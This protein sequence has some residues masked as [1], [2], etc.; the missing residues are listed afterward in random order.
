M[1]WELSMYEDP[2]TWSSC[3]YFPTLAVLSLDAILHTLHPNRDL[4]TIVS[5]LLR[6]S[7]LAQR[8]APVKVF[9]SFIISKFHIFIFPS[10]LPVANLASF[11]AHVI[12]RILSLCPWNICKL[13]IL[14]WK[15]LMIPLLSAEISHWP[16]V[17]HSIAR[18]AVS[19]AYRWKTSQS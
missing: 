9:S 1:S 12:S 14:L 18:T 8:Y 15:Y 5:I 11:G 2:R 3:P 16:D 10:S 17:D 13:F 6:H 4:Y 7:H 19:W